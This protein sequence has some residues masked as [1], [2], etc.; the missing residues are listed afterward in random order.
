[1]PERDFEIAARIAKLRALTVPHGPFVAFQEAFAWL[2]ERRRAELALGQAAEAR[3]IVVVGDSGSGKTTAAQRVVARIAAEGGIGPQDVTSFTVPS[4]A[5]LKSVGVSALDALGYPLR[6]NRTGAVIW[7]KVRD[8]LRA[9][10]TLV[11]ILDEA[12]D[13]MR[14]QSARERQAVVN[15]L[16]SLMQN[17]AWPVSLVLAGI[18]RLRN[19]PGL[20]DLLDHDPQLARRLYPIEF[21]AVGLPGPAGGI[22][23][24]VGLYAAQAEV[25]L[26]PGLIARDFADRLSQA[27]ASQFGLVVEAIIDAIDLALHE[28]AALARPHFAAAYRRKTGAI[29]GLNPFLCEDFRRVDPWRLLEQP[30]RKALEP[31]KKTS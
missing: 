8:L 20:L 17:P 14:D 4:P 30:G 2:L 15:T 12:Q 13:L 27:G 26:A 5:S 1:M 19:G 11:L 21:P 29:D 28:G 6:A 18:P 3:G 23:E 25:A 9:R 31:G 24:L 16:K 22:A 7:Q 10:R